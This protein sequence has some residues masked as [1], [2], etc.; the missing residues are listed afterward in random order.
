M[1]ET[2][3]IGLDASTQSA[4]AIAWD[5][6]G[7]LRAEGRAPI[8]IANPRLGW[9]EQDPEDWWHAAAAALRGCMADLA[10]RGGAAADVRG[11]AIANQRETLAFLGA[12]GRAVRPAMVWLDERSRG[13]VRALSAELGT[14]TIHRISGRPPDLTPA[15]YRIAWLRENEPEAFAATACFADVQTAL[16]VRLCGGAPRTGWPS[17]D[18]LGFWDMEAMDWSGTLMSAVGI[19]AG[20]LAAPHRPGTVLGEVGATAAE[21]GLPEGCPVFAGG[22]DGQ[23]A[24]LGTGCTAPGRAYV[25]LGTAV[26]SGTFSRAYAWDRAWRTELAAQGHGYILETCLRAGTFLVDW[27]ADRLAPRA[28]EGEGR[29]ARL[30]RLE[31]EAAMLPVGA[32]GVMVLPYWSGVMD[33]HWDV[34]ARG[35]I[36]GLSAS[37]GAGHVYRAILEGIALTQSAGLA[38][39]E[40]ATGTPIEQSVLIGGGAAS[41]LW[42]QMLADAGGRPVAYSS[43]TEASALGAGMIA[44]AGAGL[45]GSIEAAAAA[46]VGE[47]YAIEP[48]ASAAARYAELAEIFAPLHAATAETNRRLVAFAAAAPGE[49]SA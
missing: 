45:H 37:H 34:D 39:M 30:A 6:G 8:P 31:A 9:F 2:L 17:C 16:V 42:R 10:A 36:L 47:T 21:T 32:E 1:G 24:G 38:A 27:F 40:E 19:D 14:E 33:P 26:V 44:A 7:A 20:R 4:K 46:M 15:L 43:T 35:A 23:L 29:S 22:G 18:P 25:N 3:I 41:P 49:T 11:L 28:G 13:Q 48:D 12:D 5:A